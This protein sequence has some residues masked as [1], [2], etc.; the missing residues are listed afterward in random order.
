MTSLASKLAAA[1]NLAGAQDADDAAK[2]FG[3]RGIPG[4]PA[5]LAS[6]RRDAG[7]RIAAIDLVARPDQLGDLLASAVRQDDIVL[8]RAIAETAVKNGDSTTTTAF[9]EAFP[10]LSAAV[11]RLWTAEHRKMTTTDVKVAWRIAALKPS[12]IGSLQNHEIQAAA[13]GQTSAGSWNVG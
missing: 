11:E 6:N 1:A 10:N 8:T 9:Q 12:A 5:A 7:D 13:A 3:V 2:V 4:D